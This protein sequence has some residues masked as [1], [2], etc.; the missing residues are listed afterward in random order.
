MRR[1]DARFDPEKWRA[2]YGPWAVVTGASRGIGYAFAC[3]LA[4]AGLHIALVGRDLP[5]LAGAA[6]E[7][8]SR[9]GVQ[10]LAV[11]AD[12]AEA[13][14]R[15]LVCE[16]TADV[17]VGLVVLNAGDGCEG[18]F[19]KH[20]LD[21]ER[22]VVSL[23]VVATLELSH[24]F[25]G[26]LQRRGR[27]GLIIVSSLLAYQGAPYAANYAATKAYG[28]V[29]GESLHF[30]LRPH[31]VDVLAVT[32]GPT[33]T[34]AA[35]RVGRQRFPDSQ[36]CTASHVVDSALGA[37]GRRAS[38]VPGALNNLML[39]AGGLPARE[40]RSYMIGRVAKELAGEREV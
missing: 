20:A 13:E 19:A 17:D 33:T 27:G 36:W 31:G 22:R 10:T 28:L 29:L 14:G 21:D 4:A 5:L 18:A 1:T 9:H 24:V 34:G 7:L 37:L 25:A 39:W 11:R 8:G 35:Q 32:P 26:R 6:D 16:R 2:R 40:A 23:N 15:A 12:L 38:V 3:R 30:E